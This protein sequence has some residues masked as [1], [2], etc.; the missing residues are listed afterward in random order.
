MVVKSAVENDINKVTKVKLVVGES[1]G[2]LPDALEFAFEVLTEGT[3]C[4]G[5][6]LAMEESVLLLKCRA[7]AIEF[8]PEGYLYHCPVCGAANAI[9]IKGMEL[10]VDYYEGD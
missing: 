9:L 10:Y 2:A 1:H 4:A 8:H 7:C 3:I 6:E 5:A